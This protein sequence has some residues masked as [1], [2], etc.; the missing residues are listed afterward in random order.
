M[1]RR[2]LATSVPRESE[3]PKGRRRRERPLRRGAYLLPSLFTI[4]NIFFG[5][6]AVV[7]ALNGSFQR[8]AVLILV[9]G[10]LDT[11]DGRVARMTGTES[12]FGREFDSLADVLTCSAA[13]PTS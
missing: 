8:A 2:E 7:S 9:A 13:W 6:Y 4:G 1:R 11:L 12:A 5:F 10:I 3:P